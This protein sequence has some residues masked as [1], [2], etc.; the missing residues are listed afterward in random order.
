MLNRKEETAFP[1]PPGDD[2]VPMNHMGMSLRDYFAGQAMTAQMRHTSGLN[3]S[4]TQM[5]EIASLAY[6]MADQMLEE[7]KK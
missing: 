2:V 1:I 5:A 7:R 6:A 4:V 3:G